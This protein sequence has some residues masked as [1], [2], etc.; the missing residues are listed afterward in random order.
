MPSVFIY[1]RDVKGPHYNVFHSCDEEHVHVH[2]HDSQVL[3]ATHIKYINQNVNIENIMF[4]HIRI[5]LPPAVKQIDNNRYKNKIENK[6]SE[7]N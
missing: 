4:R 5:T 3:K 7:R 1:K 2:V 6:R